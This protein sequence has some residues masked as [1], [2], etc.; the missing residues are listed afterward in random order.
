MRS[1]ILAP[2]KSCII[3]SLILV[4]LRDLDVLRSSILTFLSEFLLF[5][6]THLGLPQGS[7]R[8]A[9]PHLG[10][11]LGLMSYGIHAY[12]RML[13]GLDVLDEITL[14]DYC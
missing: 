3:R 11:S 8:R 2:Y 7:R 10:L 6:L 1:S 9:L 13:I 5:M 14:L 4:Y 12:T